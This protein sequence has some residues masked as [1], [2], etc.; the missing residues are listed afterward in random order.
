[1]GICGKL[2][3]PCRAPADLPP[4]IVAAAQANGRSQDIWHMAESLLADLQSGR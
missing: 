2:S 1:M 3:I 4:E